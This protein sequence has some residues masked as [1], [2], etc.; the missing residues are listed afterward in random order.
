[1]AVEHAVLRI[2]TVPTA[3]VVLGRRGAAV[4]IHATAP[5][6]YLWP[7][8]HSGRAARAGQTAQVVCYKVSVCRCFI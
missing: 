3:G 4:R 2:A 8:A 6:H 5:S 1:M 7:M